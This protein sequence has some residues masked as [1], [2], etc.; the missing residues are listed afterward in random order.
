[1]FIISISNSDYGRATKAHLEQDHPDLAAGGVPA[2]F[3]LDRGF[4]LV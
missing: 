3:P 4:S 1:M 2:R